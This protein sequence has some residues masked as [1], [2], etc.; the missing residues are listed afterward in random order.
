MPPHLKADKDNII[1]YEKHLIDEL[2]EKFG[3]L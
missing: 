1:N 3:L 2:K